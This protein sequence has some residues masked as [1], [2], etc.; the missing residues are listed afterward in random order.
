M[1][2]SAAF[3]VVLLSAAYLAALGVAA[4]VR[5]D[6]TREFLSAF[7][8]SAG[9]H[10]TELAFRLL[11]GGA[12]VLTAPRMQ[13]SQAF[14]VFGWVLVGTTLLL[15]LVPWRVHR[16]FADWSVPQTTRFMPL[17]GAGSLAGGLL[18]L[19]ALLLRPAAG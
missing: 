6:R 10:F 18:L 14:A 11:A 9:V 15:A 4:M 17:F 1:I 12:L 8:S 3:I 7:A 13:F 19:G 16:R 5:P 2:A